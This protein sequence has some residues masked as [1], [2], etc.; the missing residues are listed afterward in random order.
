MSE[1]RLVITGRLGL[2]PKEIEI[3]FIRAS[4]PGGQNVNKVSSAVQ[5]R[6]DAARSPSLP[7]IVRRRALMLAGRRATKDGVIVLTAQ[8]H[9]TQERNRADA[10]DRL[11]ELLQ[12]AADIPKAR[13][14]TKVTRGAR[15]RR[16]KGKKRRGAVKAK[17]RVE[18]ADDWDG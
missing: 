3:D 10:V 2:D 9:R 18:G 11:I 4:G 8:S 6:F 14:A 12:R 15:E 13:V 5:L 16:I 7:D 1:D 17:R